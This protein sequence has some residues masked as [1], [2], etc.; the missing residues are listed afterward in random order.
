MS[1]HRSTHCG[2]SENRQNNPILA[3]CTLIGDAATLTSDTK[4]DNFAIMIILLDLS[5]DPYHV[6]SSSHYQPVNREDYL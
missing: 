2:P 6:M 4:H 1:Q 5:L 3:R